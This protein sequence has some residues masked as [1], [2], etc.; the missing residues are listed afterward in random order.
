MTDI[1]HD[2]PT[3]P[4]KED[5]ILGA[6]MYFPGGFILPYLLGLGHHP[7]VLFHL[8]QGFFLFSLYVIAWILPIPGV[9]TFA[10]LP[11]LILVVLHAYKAYN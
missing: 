11:Y 3:G 5:R 2:M 10:A 9:G 4:N 7:F 1:T 8:K 6:L